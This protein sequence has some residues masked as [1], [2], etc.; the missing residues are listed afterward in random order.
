M[1]LYRRLY[2]YYYE[3]EIKKAKNEVVI[4]HFTSSFT[5]MRPWER[6][7]IKHPYALEWDDYFAQLEFERK[8]K[9][10]KLSCRLYEFF[11]HN[12]LLF[13]IG[14]IHSYFKPIFCR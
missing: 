12:M 13:G 2:K 3:Y 7:D 4:I 9:N 11:P 1:Q 10:K 14:I 8:E 6:G 5:S